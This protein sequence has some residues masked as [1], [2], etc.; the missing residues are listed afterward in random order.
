MRNLITTLAAIVALIGCAKES[1]Q[2]TTN[3]I[4]VTPAITTPVQ[5]VNR[6]AY[7][8][9][10]SNTRGTTPKVIRVYSNMPLGGF[11]VGWQ[12][13][14]SQQYSI[15]GDTLFFIHGGNNGQWKGYIENLGGDSVKVT[16][17][18]VFYGRL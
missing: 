17:L 11:P 13:I 10:Y 14:Q 7:F 9:D 16:A 15:I 4:I 5:G 1:A 18:G 6:L 12:S 8:W 3:P 2:P